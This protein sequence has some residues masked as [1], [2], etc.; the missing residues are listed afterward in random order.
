MDDM[1]TKKVWASVACDT[2]IAVGRRKM[3]VNP[4]NN[5]CI[6]TALSAAIPNTFTQRRSSFFQSQIVRVTVNNPTNDAIILWPCS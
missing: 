5:P 2:E 6:M 1:I 4:P 3:T